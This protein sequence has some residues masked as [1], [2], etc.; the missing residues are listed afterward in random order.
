MTQKWPDK[1]CSQNQQKV[2]TPH[3]NWQQ[4]T[5]SQQTSKHVWWHHKQKGTI[6]QNSELSSLLLQIYQEVKRHKFARCP[7]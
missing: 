5:T 6:Q 1:I 2:N 7:A 4:N 3:D